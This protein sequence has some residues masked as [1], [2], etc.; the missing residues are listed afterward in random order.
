MSRS[1][2]AVALL[3]VLAT[4]AASLTL[5]VPTTQALELTAAACGAAVGAGIL[6]ALLLRAAERR[7]LST[8]SILVTLTPVAAV[9]G[10][11]MAAS[12]WML[13]SM[14]PTAALGVVLVASGT[15]GIVASQ[16]LGGRLRTGSERLIA[17]TR[18]IGGGDLRTHVQQPAVEELA[19]LAHEL[20]EMQRRLEKSRARE[21]A[22]T[23]ARRE[24]VSWISHDLRTPVARVRAIV[25]ALED[26][27]I[28]EPADAAGYLA[29]LHTEADRLGILIADLFELNGIAAGELDLALEPT[30]LVEVV[31]DVV[32]SFTVIATARGVALEAPEPAVDPEVMI[33]PR[34]LERA[35][36][37]LLDNA[38]RHTEPGGTVTVQILPHANGVAIAVDDSCGGADLPLLQQL[39]ADSSTPQPLGSGGRT[40]LGLAIAKGLVTAQDGRIAVAATREGCRFTIA[41]G[42]TERQPVA[43]SATLIVNGRPSRSS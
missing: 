1:A 30:R 18:R 8:Q 9:A 37:N 27:V 4:L 21:R 41:L 40:A 42:V 7:S 34:H 33:S 2:A 36:G 20:E 38:L 10:G 13:A 31:S 5:P 16:T 17:A 35:L 26:D 15:L 32:A 23:E 6:G 24:L 22:L 3:G 25:E 11:A 28:S 43:A 14:H 39:L 29:Q 12:H 19:D